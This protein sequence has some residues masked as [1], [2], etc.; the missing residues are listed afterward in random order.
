ILSVDKL[1]TL[2]I[3]SQDKAVI[4]RE[5]PTNNKLWRINVSE[6]TN[7][8][9][10]YRCAGGYFLEYNAVS[11]KELVKIVNRKYQTLA[12]YGYEKQELSKLVKEMR[13][14]GIDRI[15]PIGKTTDFSLIWDGYDLINSL[16]RKCVI[17]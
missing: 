3:Q 14:N 15:V 8:I 7:D 5:N 12:Y 1:S 17:L 11:L 2:Y 16:S 4:K 13:F 9:D 6:L 10:K